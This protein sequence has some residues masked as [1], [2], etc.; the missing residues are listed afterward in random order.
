MKITNLTNSPFD[1]INDKGEKERL[2]ARGELTF[3]PHHM[4][5]ASYRRAQYF[6]VEEGEVLEAAKEE[7]KP[8]EVVIEEEI[9]TEEESDPVDR[10]AEYK[11]L[12]GKDA[13]KR[14]SDKRLA[15]EIAKLK[16]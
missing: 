7:E 6:K 12:S 1:L 2:P 9:K 14:W 16:G 3:E 13:D 8:E 15:E 10:H 11:E 5:A 4:H